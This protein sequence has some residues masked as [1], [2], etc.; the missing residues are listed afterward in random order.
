MGEQDLWNK[1]KVNQ[2][3]VAIV[4]VAVVGVASQTLRTMIAVV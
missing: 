2:V 4:N 3:V 1:I